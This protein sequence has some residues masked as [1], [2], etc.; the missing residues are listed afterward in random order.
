MLTEFLSLFL[1]LSLSLSPPLTCT[2]HRDR[3]D[4]Q[5][6]AL[7]PLQDRARRFTTFGTSASHLSTSTVRA[8]L[9]EEEEEEEE[10]PPSELF[11]PGRPKNEQQQQHQQLQQQFSPW[12]LRRFGHR[13][14][15]EHKRASLPPLSSVCVVISTLARSLLLP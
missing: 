13:R 10:K 8:T 9:T 3:T 4:K 1:S 7:S 6:E 14:A 15:S 5:L 11:C 2:N 12:K